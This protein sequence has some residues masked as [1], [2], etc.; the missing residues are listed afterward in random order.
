MPPVPAG[1]KTFHFK[2]RILDA[3][4]KPFAEREYL[5][6]WGKERVR[7]TTTPDGD[8]E[9]LLAGGVDRGVLHLG[10]DEGGFNAYISI[11]ITRVPHYPPP[12][13]PIKIEPPKEP[14]PPMGMP[15]PPIGPQAESSDVWNEY[16]RELREWEEYERQ[17]RREEELEEQ[18]RRELEKYEREYAKE[19]EQEWESHVGPFPLPPPVGTSPPTSQDWQD[20]IDRLNRARRDAY[21]RYR[22]QYELFWRLRNLG[23]VIEE[24]RGSA[25]FVLRGGDA[26][27]VALEFGC[28]SYAHKHDLTLPERLDFE[29]VPVPAVLVDLLQHLKTVHD[30]NQWASL[31][32]TP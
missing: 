14:R 23:F 17:R 16:Q 21:D 6:V 19:L 11:P 8:V 29:A 7:G 27:R 31:G 13:P 2:T 9:A 22:V 24:F 15:Q 18:A 3:D 26:S 10:T 25:S 32:P 30:T 1:P 28:R 12:P 4:A 5:I 20:R